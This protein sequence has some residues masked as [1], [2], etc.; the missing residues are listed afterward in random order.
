MARSLIGILRGITSD[1]IEDA[2]T[3]LLEAGIDKIE[4]P[5]NSPDPFKTIGLMVDKFKG[6]GIFGA[7]TVTDVSQVKQLVEIGCELV[8]SPNCDPAVIHATKDAGMLSYPGVMTPSEC[9]MALKAGAD[10]LKFFP[11]DLVGVK[12]LKAIKTVLPQ[13][14]ECYA[15][16]GANAS[17][18]GDWIDA[19]ATGFGIGSA[20]YKAGMS[21][22]DLQK[23]AELIV[24][25]Y[26]AA[27]SD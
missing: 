10:G 3:L 17:N 20:L 7:G 23:N 18:F 25:A 16:G 11:G 27:I 21:M 6:Q 2:V 26:D 8:V 22:G 19:G 12:G 9:F 5:L 15:V 1:E 24:S 13:E 14:T 4:V